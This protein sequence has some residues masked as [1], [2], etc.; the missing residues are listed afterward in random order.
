M[1]PPVIAVDGLTVSFGDFRAVQEVSLEV[2]ADD[3]YAIVGES[4]CGKSTLAYSLLNLVPPPGRITS[5]EVVFRGQSVTRMSKNELRQLRG[6]RVGMVFQAAMN[7]FNPV[8][9]IGRQIDH[10][11]E[12]HTEI[13]SDPREGRSYFAELLRKV[14]LAPDQIWG[15][16]EHQLSGGMKQR[17]A[18]ATALLLRPPVIV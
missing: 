7:S 3:I 4:G 2:R 14:H 8:I 5:G 16:Y 10:M 17:V 1:T 9:T 15:A 12:A 18:I 13:F 6:P 11:L